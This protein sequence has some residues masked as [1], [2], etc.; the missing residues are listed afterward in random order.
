MMHE[1]SIASAILELARRKLPPACGLTAVHVVAGPMRAIESDAMHFAWQAVVADAGF[2]GVRLD[3][4]LATWTLECP[5]CHARWK[6]REF[7]DGCACGRAHGYPIG[8]DELQLVSIEVDE[9][10]KES[11]HASVGGAE[12]DEA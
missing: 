4:E 7:D 1:L 6:S 3:L 8:G 10:E 12:R 9:R 2:P 11:S 5:V